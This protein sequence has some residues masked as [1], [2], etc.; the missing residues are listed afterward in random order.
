MRRIIYINNLDDTP[1]FRIAQL[2]QWL[3]Y[4][5]IGRDSIPDRAE[6]LLLDTV[7]YVCVSVTFFCHHKTPLR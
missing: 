7:S 5:L 4:C 3:V 1:D 2:V 6:I